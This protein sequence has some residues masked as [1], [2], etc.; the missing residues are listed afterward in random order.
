MTNAQIVAIVNGFSDFDSEKKIN[1]KSAYAII[2]NRKEL[3]NALIP[4]NESLNLIFEKYNT[5]ANEFTNLPSEE[6]E[7]IG[8][9]INELLSIEVDVNV[10]K[11]KIDDLGNCD[12]SLKELEILDF[13]IEE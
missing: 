5:S 10:I 6:L 7:K 8:K 13:M 11:L 9:E 2:K 3:L 1:I 12:I 4:Y